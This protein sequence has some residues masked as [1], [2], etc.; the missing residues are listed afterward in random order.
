M[1]TAALS[2]AA[3][4]VYAVLL[5]IT[6]SLPRYDCITFVVFVACIFRELRFANERTRTVTLHVITQIFLASFI[7]HLW[8]I[9]YEGRNAVF[10]GILPWSDSH[11]YYE[12]SL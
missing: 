2:I 7:I 1:R 5:A 9:G 6:K 8:T 10:G 11:D 4:L 3:A 12:D